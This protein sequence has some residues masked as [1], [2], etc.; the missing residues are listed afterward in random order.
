MTDAPTGNLFAVLGDSLAGFRVQTAL[1]S[2][3]IAAIGTDTGAIPDVIRAVL[4]AVDKALQ[5]LARV[6]VTVRELIIPADA[7]IA[8]IEVIG[9]TVEALGKGLSLGGLAGLPDAELKNV[10]DLIGE[11]GEAINE[12]A[13]MA[14]TVLPNPGDIGVIQAELEALL[15]HVANPDMEGMGLLGELR[16]QIKVPSG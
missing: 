4:A 6:V 7:A 2:E 15:G 9:D 16:G 8:L 14:G 1:A 3:D 10:G 13:Q 11:G 5:E 12:L